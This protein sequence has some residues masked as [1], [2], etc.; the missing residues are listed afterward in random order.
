MKYYSTKRYRPPQPL[1]VGRGGIHG[2]GAR[3]RPV[4]TRSVSRRWIWS[5]WRSWRS[6]L[7]RYGGLLA[8][9]IMDDMDPDMLR[10]AVHAA[11]DFPISLHEVGDGLYTLE[12]FHGPTFAFKRFRGAVHGARGGAAQRRAAAYRAGGNVGA[13]RAAPWRTVSAASRA[14]AW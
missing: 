6:V 12:L 3:R 7:C 8:A 14:C 2:A 5:G 9:A 4:C 11:Y 13:T 10:G 1:R